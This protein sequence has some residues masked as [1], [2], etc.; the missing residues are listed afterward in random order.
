MSA[1]FSPFE[2]ICYQRQPQGFLNVF[3]ENWIDGNS[4]PQNVLTYLTNMCEKPSG[5][6]VLAQANVQ[7]A[8]H[9]YKLWYNQPKKLWL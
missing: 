2:I 1:V 5:I 8:E 4:E 9:K 7:K 3:K 6:S